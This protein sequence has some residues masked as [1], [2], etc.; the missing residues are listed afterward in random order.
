MSSSGPIASILIGVVYSH[1]LAK[2]FKFDRKRVIAKS[3]CHKEP[4]VYIVPYNINL[5]PTQILYLYFIFT[6]RL[7]PFPAPPLYLLSDSFGIIGK[8]YSSP[9]LYIAFP[10]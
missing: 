7:D 10:T 3:S 4:G 9:Q 2:H 6:K 1:K 8:E 5:F